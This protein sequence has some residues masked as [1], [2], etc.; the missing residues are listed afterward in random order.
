MTLVPSA[1]GRLAYGDLM[2]SEYS[3]H[4]RVSL[5]TNLLGQAKAEVLWEGSLDSLQGLVCNPRRWEF[6]ESC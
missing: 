1:K 3:I 2:G 4:V 6:M 5:E